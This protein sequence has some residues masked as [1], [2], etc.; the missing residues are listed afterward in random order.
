MWQLP[1]CDA[2]AA[3]LVQALVSEIPSAA[4][5]LQGLLA[6]DAPL[7]LWSVCRAPDGSEFRDLSSAAA[8]LSSG[9]VAT[10]NWD[11]E[12]PRDTEDASQDIREACIQTA[13]T[14]LRIAREA[15]RLALDECPEVARQAYWLGLL[16]NALP[17]LCISG[18]AVNMDEARRGGSCLPRW[19]VT[20]LDQMASGRADERTPAS[21]VV[22]AFQS[23]AAD[24]DGDERLGQRWQ[25]AIPSIRHS[26]PGLVGMLNRK[27]ELEVAFDETLQR[28]KLASLKQLAYG[29]GHEINNPLANISTRAQTLLRDESDPERR[30]KLATITSQAFR[31]HEMIADMML[32]ASPPAL[33]IAQ[34]DLIPLIDQII[35]E[36]LPL[37]E[38]HV[39]ELHR[40]DGH[41]RLEVA[42]DGV[43]LAVALK[44]ICQNAIEAIGR[45]GRV[46]LAVQEIDAPDG[47][48]GASGW[49]EISV[50]DTGPGITSEIRRHLF[51]PFFSGREAGRG[52]GFG[53]P[54]AW[55][56]V[57]DHGGRIEVDSAPGQG[58]LFAIRLP[59]QRPQA[60]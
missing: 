57:T 19:L 18:P 29:A 38:Q 40:A 21:Y 23:A 34:V 8:W 9:A 36:L 42:A 53:L 25:I 58:T 16:H 10:L 47:Q 45:G 3:V 22:A 60:E 14:G 41:A 56:I 54:K 12:G 44:G 11:R 20:A 7:A 59:A 5:L 43:Q 51:D 24:D 4:R 33:E 49:I 15:Q 46:E 35:E 37:A 48:A 50:R 17:W 30:R 32:F 1:L 2:S 31:A 27:H 39:T 26:L 6:E 13:A 28:E 52:L 55:R